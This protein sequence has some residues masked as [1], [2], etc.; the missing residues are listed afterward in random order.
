MDPISLIACSW[1][2]S[3]V[4]N[5]AS[6]LSWGTR[7]PQNGFHIFDHISAIYV[8][9]V[10]CTSGTFVWGY[11]NTYVRNVLLVSLKQESY[12]LWDLIEVYTTVIV[13]V[14]LLKSATATVL[15][16]CLTLSTEKA[17]TNYRFTLL[18]SLLVGM[19]CSVGKAC[20]VYF[21]HLK[22]HASKM[23]IKWH[24]IEVSIEIFSTIAAF[25]LLAN[26]VKLQN[27]ILPRK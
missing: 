9:W 7:N 18:L 25:L 14:Q 26:G 21:L 15:A 8:L 27:T 17:R 6:L 4:V 23:P 16:L 11:M 3:V 19:L 13:A 5:T 2:L 1:G 20:I 10:V 22:V 12:V 24:F